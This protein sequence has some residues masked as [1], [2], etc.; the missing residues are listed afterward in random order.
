LEIDFRECGEN[1]SL[2]DG[3]RMLLARLPS[4]RGVW[5][6][7]TSN[8]SVDIFCGLFLASSNRGFGISPEVSALLSDRGLEV[9]FDVYFD[10][11]SQL[12]V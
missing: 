7:L 4:D 1:D 12:A 6:S 2:D 5:A 11:S 10:P 3:I 9:G 8:Y